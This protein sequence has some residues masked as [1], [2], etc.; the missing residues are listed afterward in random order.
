MR[1]GKLQTPIVLLSFKLISRP[2][3][4]K[5]IKFVLLIPWSAGNVVVV[6]SAGMSR[7]RSEKSNSETILPASSNIFGMGS[8]SGLPTEEYS[9][10]RVDSMASMSVG[11]IEVEFAEG[12][13][14]GEGSKMLWYPEFTLVGSTIAG[15]NILL[16]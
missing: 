11:T 4:A 2:S 3:K 16:L 6:W 12:L 9:K 13:G 15:V 8:E 10:N 7:G 14:R 5:L 1:H